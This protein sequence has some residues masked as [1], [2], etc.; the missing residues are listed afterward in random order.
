MCVC[1]DVV[2]SEITPSDE[3]LLDCVWTNPG[4]PCPISVQEPLI[5]TGTLQDRASQKSACLTLSSSKMG[6]LMLTFY[7]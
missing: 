4:F 2:K 7:L 1:L 6:I 3:T 5:W